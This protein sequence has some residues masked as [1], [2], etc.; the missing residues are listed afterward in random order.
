MRFLIFL[1]DRVLPY[2]LLIAIVGGGLGGIAWLVAATYFWNTS[3]LTVLVDE[4]VTSAE[5]HV[6]SRLVYRDFQIFSVLYPFHIV[7][8][9]SKTVVCSNKE[10]IF[11]A[12]PQGDAEIFFTT[13]RGISGAEHVLIESNTQGKIDLQSVILTKEV[14]D[15]VGAGF[16]EQKIDTVPTGDILY[17]NPIQGLFLY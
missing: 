8:P 17:E 14:T 3:E 1:R 5:I 6:S 9:W 13:E 7:L 10:C 12:L 4:G 16:I 15:T 11:P 2:I